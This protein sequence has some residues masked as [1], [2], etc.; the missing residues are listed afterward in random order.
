MGP[1]RWAHVVEATAERDRYVDALR[2]SALTAV[3]VGHWLVPV[4]DPVGDDY[5]VR[6]VMAEQP[7][8]EWATWAFQVMP[9]FFIVGGWANA[10][11]WTRAQ[12]RGESATAWASRRARR[13]LRPLVVVIAVWALAAAA[14]DTL[15]I[16]GRWLT[17]ASQGALVPAWFL[18]V[19][20]VVTVAVPVTVRAE[21]RVGLVVVAALVVAAAATDALTMAGAEAAQWTNFA[22]V[23]FA[24]HQLGLRWHERGL[25]GPAGGLALLVAGLGAL[26]AL[27]TVG[28]YP[29]DM[30]AEVDGRT[31]ATPP[32]VAMISLATAQLGI[33]AAA[34]TVLERGLSRDRVWALVALAGRRI[35]TVF[36]WHMTALVAVAALLAFAGSLP[37]HE[38]LGWGW[39]PTRPLWLALCAVALGLLVVAFGRAEHAPRRASAAAPGPVSLAA[40]AAVT[41][42]TVGVLAADGVHDPGG[43][44]GLALWPLIGLAG[45]LAALGVLEPDRA[46]R[47]QPR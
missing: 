32:S 7:W 21:R 15:G 34:R 38:A 13:L 2:V 16:E 22:W 26:A 29:V 35:M 25:P 5:A 3:V 8:T 12:A 18:A 1:A 37:L 44:L 36:L 24:V 20:V 28:G 46:M 14:G 30:V 23:W 17:V 4:F 41:A 11:A 27:V 33:I 6:F 9:V 47:R 40:G 45:G 39:W 42:L 31:N 43:P 10:S 19:Y